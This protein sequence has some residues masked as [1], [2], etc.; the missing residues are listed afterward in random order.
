MEEKRYEVELVYRQTVRYVVEAP[1]RK[2]AE[3]LALERWQ[4][5][6]QGFALGHELCEVE[7]VQAEKARDE[8]EF[9]RDRDKVLRFLR[10]RELVIEEL[11]PDAFNPSVHDAISAED[12]AIRLEWTRTGPEG[13]RVRDVPRATRALEELCREHR[14]VCFTRPRV[15]RGE[16]GEIRLYCTP[17]HLEKLA[18]LLDEVEPEAEP[19]A[20]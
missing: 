14:V 17:Q 20:V 7:S 5:G 2:A 9:A 12:V 16:R 8:E 13:A 1:S 6:E 4:R 3:K 18:S 19:E 11:D 15:R 10:D